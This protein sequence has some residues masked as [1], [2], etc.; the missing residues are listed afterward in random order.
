[1]PK[2]P[3]QQLKLLYLAR[4]LREQTDELHGLTL[5]ELADELAKYDI[6]VERKTLYDDLE[7][8]RLCGYDVRVK[9]D[10]RVRYYLGNP[11]FDLAERKLLTDAVQS[12]KFIT[13][14]QS[15]ELIRKI[16]RLGSRYEA[17]ILQGQ[18]YS[19]NRL[20]AEN[21]DIYRNIATLLRAI[22]ENKKIRC[23]YFEWNARKQRILRH[24]GA[25]YTLS[26][27][28]LSWEDENYYLVAFDSEA[29]KIKHFRVDKILNIT[30]TE[31]RREGERAF[32]DFD[33]ALYARSTFGMYGGEPCY[34]QIECANSLAGVVIDRFGT[35]VTVLSNREDRFVF[36]AK[37]HISPTF[38]SWVLGFGADMKVLAPDHVAA[39]VAELAREV[40]GQY[41]SD[42]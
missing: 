41:R 29:E 42:T 15:G 22:A 34:V 8:L 25:F 30:L 3:N 4:I 2:H 18:V 21:E 13:H 24:D 37:V 9:R 20:K 10:R 32:A 38:Y 19:A 23:R 16:G 11:E 35:D 17:Q 27:L 26:P 33:M 12:A 7:I 14:K 31:E 39:R 5:T 1:M 36:S 40:L 6:G 28:A